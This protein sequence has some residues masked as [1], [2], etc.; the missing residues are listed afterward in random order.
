MRRAVHQRRVGVIQQTGV[1]FT[2]NAVNKQVRVIAW[3][4][5]HRQD[6][7]GAGIG[8]HN[9]CAAARQQGFNILLKLKVEGQIDVMPR[10]RRHF[11]KLANHA[12]T[13]VNLNLFIAGLPVQDIFVV[14][15]NT[16]LTDVVRCGVVRQLAVF[17]EAV[18]VFVVNLGDVANHM[19][20]RGSVRVVATLVPL[21][22]HAGETVLVYRKAG[23]LDFR[24]VGFNRDGGES[25]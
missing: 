15:F 24:Q 14:A 6:A 21:Y 2:G 8:D 16:E 19:R 3:H 13:V 1:V 10:L 22:F 20:Q 5:H 4:R 11:F 25:V 12:A 9:G 17:I 18:D 7:A 23:H